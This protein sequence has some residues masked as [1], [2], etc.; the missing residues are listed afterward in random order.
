MHTVIYF[1]ASGNDID[2]AVSRIDGYLET[3]NFFDYYTILEK[4]G[5]KLE[6]KRA[7]LLLWQEKYDWKK[8]ADEAYTEAEKLKAQGDL[9]RAGYYYRKAGSLYEQ[10]LISDA[11]IYNIDS[12]DY[13]IPEDEKGEVN[14]EYWFC[15]PVDFHV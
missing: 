2:D 13:T 4:Q 1:I 8:A 7:E 11:I 5:G 15:I 6:E 3:E 10:L 12:Y 9:C 14:N